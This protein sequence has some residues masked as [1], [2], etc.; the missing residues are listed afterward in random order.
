MGMRLGFGYAIWLG[1]RRTQHGTVELVL[2]V[3]QVNAAHVIG[4]G[5]T[6][7]GVETVPKGE[8][9]LLAKGLE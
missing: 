4:Q 7:G 8:H 6:L 5:G 9:V 3:S 2:L 1:S